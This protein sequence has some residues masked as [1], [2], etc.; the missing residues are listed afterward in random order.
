MRINKITR[1]V[2]IEVDG[3][4][5]ALRLTLGGLEQL[6]KTTGNLI[7]TLQGQPLPSLTTLSTAFWLGLGGAKKI[8]KGEAE[9]ILSAYLAEY[10]M[11]GSEGDGG[12]NLFYALIAASGILGR[13][14]SADILSQFGL[15]E[16]ETVAEKN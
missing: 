16:K 12:V 5:Y 4:E 15:A 1:E 3:K 13:Q 7:T 9:T 2:F 10:G 14:A 11:G 8:S 6:E